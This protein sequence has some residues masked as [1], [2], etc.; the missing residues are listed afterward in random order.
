M[1]TFLVEEARKELVGRDLMC[2]CHPLKCHGDLLLFV[3]GGG[4]L[5]EWDP[6]EWKAK[7][8]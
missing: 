7:S 4:E 1:N 5:S 3:A 2:W 6:V 8:T